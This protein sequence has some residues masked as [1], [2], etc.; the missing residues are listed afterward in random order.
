MKKSL[1]I[2]LAWVIA[3]VASGKA[4]DS[5]EAAIGKIQAAITNA[6]PSDPAKVREMLPTLVALNNQVEALRVTTDQAVHLCRQY[7]TQ[8]KGQ[9]QEAAGNDPAVAEAYQKIYRELV[10]KSEQGA[11]MLKTLDTLAGQ[12]AARIAEVEVT[13]GP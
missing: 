6:W 4:P 13:G 3:N 7:A 9:I 10:L 11:K 12:I 8:L 5:P 2:L 1:I